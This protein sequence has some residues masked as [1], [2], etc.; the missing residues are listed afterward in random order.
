MG[1]HREVLKSGVC[2]ACGCTDEWACDGGCEWTDSLHTMCSE[3]DLKARAFLAWSNH[4]EVQAMFQQRRRRR[5]QAAA[6]KGGRT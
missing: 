1:R 4:T 2:F 6:P 5:A 3:C